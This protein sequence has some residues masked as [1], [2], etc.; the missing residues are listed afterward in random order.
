LI[1]KHGCE[2]R[3]VLAHELGHVLGRLPDIAIPER[4][5][6]GSDRWTADPPVLL[7]REMSACAGSTLLT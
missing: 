6:Y 4:L 7:S 5:M 3:Y 2:K 1:I